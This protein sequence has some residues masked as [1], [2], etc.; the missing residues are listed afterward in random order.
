MINVIAIITAKPGKREE[1]LAAFRA[2]MAAVHAEPVFL[3]LPFRSGR[4][5]V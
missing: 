4:A 5:T 3:T 2:N 1:V